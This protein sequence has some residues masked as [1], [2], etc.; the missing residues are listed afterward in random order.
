[1]DELARH[2][3]VTEERAREDIEGGSILAVRL[4]PE[5]ELRVPRVQLEGEGLMTGLRDV[6]AAMHVRD[7]WM[8]LQLLLDEDVIGPLRAGRLNDAIRAVD[9]YLP[10]DEGQSGR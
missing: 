2:L 8:R 7:P 4:D 1:M 9:S 3:G 6:L 5:G 10:R